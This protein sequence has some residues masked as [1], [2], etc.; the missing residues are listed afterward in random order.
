M[1][2]NELP[3]IELLGIKS[4]STTSWPW[5]AGQWPALLPLFPDGKRDDDGCFLRELWWEV[6][7]LL[8]VKS[9]ESSL[10][11]RHFLMNAY[12]YY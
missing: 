4:H 2:K 3:G 1:P 9:S 11:P 8:H 5:D 7:E 12:G 6:R 10:L